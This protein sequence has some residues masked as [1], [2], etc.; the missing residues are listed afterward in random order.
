MI[1]SEGKQEQLKKNLQDGNQWVRILYM[2]F[3]WI[4]LYFVLMVTGLII[5]VQILFALITGSDNENLRKFAADLTKYINQIILFLTYNDDRKPFPFATWGKVD[6]VKP[7]TKPAP[8]D[9]IDEHEAVIEIE[10][11]SKEDT[12]EK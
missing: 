3:F 8:S 5:F 1:M 7:V 4:V 9:D 2:V 10:P 11:E 12:P 6:K